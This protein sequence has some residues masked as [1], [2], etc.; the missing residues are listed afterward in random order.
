MKCAVCGARAVTGAVV[1]YECLQSCKDPRS[2]VLAE[3]EKRFDAL[4]NPDLPYGVNHNYDEGYR[5]GLAMAMNVIKDMQA[6]K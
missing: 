3:V 2:W 5:M 1:H 4:K 6:G